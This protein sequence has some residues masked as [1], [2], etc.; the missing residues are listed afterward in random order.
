MRSMILIACAALV[1]A[2]AAAGCRKAE[3]ASQGATETVI[4]QKTCPI[5]GGAIDKDFFV[6]HEG[7]KIYFCCAACV[8]AFKEDPEKYVKKVDE[9]L[10]KAQ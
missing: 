8:E 9:E 5:M 6:E 10:K 3:Q 2:F 1:I 7:R 4:A